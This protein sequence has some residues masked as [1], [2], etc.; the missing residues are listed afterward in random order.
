M[1]YHLEDSPNPVPCAAIGID[2]RVIAYGDGFFTTMAVVDGQIN[3]LAYHLDRIMQSLQ[4]LQLAP[5]VGA[6]CAD[7]C[8]SRAIIKT[9][10]KSYAKQLGQG[11]IKL[12][13][14]RQNQPIAGYGFINQAAHS[15]VKLM[16]TP[17]PLASAANQIQQQPA[18]TAVCLTQQIA[19]LPPPLS[20][21]KLLNAQD[22]VLASRELWQRQTSEATLIEGL[23]QDISG[24][25]VEGTFCN[26]FYQLNGNKTWYTPPITQSGVKGV[27]R[28]VILDSFACAQQPCQQRVLA[29]HDM[30]QM[31]GLFFCNAVR[32][33]IPI[34][35]LIDPKNQSHTLH[36]PNICQLKPPN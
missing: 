1:W 18:A 25:W 24:N 6:P 14:C 15:W 17:Q 34:T 2:A 8:Q 30:S 3:W 28:Q 10:L 35:T 11:I 36:I 26:F 19:C 7:L 12:I 4:A 16:P 9:H 27:M 32:G 31:S 5:K 20:G 33:I 21:L 29:T 23:V 22:K 13:I